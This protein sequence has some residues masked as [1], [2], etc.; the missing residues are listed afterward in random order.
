[1]TPTLSVAA[2]HVSAA[3]LVPPVAFGVPVPP[4]AGLLEETRATGLFSA[5]LAV[6]VVATAASPTG[7]VGGR[8]S[9][10]ARVRRAS[11]ALLALTGAAVIWAWAFRH[12]LRL[13]GG[14][15]FILLNLARRVLI[16]REVA[17]RH[18]G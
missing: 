7:Y 17:D 18:G 13:G 2:V 6:G 9:D 8:S 11:L 3:V 10:P 14:L 12:N 1:M 15:P 5:A 16:A 4:L